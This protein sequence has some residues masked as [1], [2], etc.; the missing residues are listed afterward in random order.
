MH[1]YCVYIVFVAQY[2]VYYKVGRV[3]NDTVLDGG[4]GGAFRVLYAVHR[5]K[6]L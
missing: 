3:I 6:T 4:G 1:Q 2:T 5:M